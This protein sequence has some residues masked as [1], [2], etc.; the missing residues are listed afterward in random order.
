M[1]R[2]PRTGWD[3]WLLDLGKG[4]EPR[5]VLRTPFQEFLPSL[6]PDGRWM[7]FVSDESGRM[8]IYLQ[9]FSDPGER[10]RI[11][12][13]GGTLPR[14]R[15][16]G[17]ELFYLSADARLVAVPVDLTGTPEVGTPQRLFGLGSAVGVDVLDRYDVISDGQRFLTIDSV[18]GSGSEVI[19]ILD[20]EARLSER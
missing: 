15:G 16:D 14:W 8:E 2:H 7:A 20:W 10:I 9:R 19:V 3:L 4:G 11:S 13:D 12:T 1:D 5:P 18:Q 6:S 17:R